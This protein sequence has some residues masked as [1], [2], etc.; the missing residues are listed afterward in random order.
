MNAWDISGNTLLK[1]SIWNNNEELRTVLV[2][3]GSDMG[4]PRVQLAMGW[5]TV[6]NAWSSS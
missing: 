6:K 1:W 3:A 2:D 4:V 5:R